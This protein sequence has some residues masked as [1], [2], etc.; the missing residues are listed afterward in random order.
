MLFLGLTLLGYISYRNLALELLPSVELPFLIIQVNSSREMDPDY[1]EK[2]AIIPLE[3]AIGTLEG[4]EK[5]ESYCGRRDGRII[6]YYIS[7]TNLKFAYLKMQ[8]KVDAVKPGLPDEFFV[9]VVKIDTELLTNMFMNLQ[10]RGGGGIDRVRNIFENQIRKELAAIDGIA[11]V[12]VFGGRE[13][14]VEIILNDETSA[15]YDIT[16][17]IVRS[18]IA[19]NTQRKMYV[20]QL[21]HQQNVIFIN[22]S[23][24]Y[25]DITDLENIVVKPEVPVLLKDVAKINFDV[26]EETSISRVNGKDAVT[27]QLIR[28][29]RINI[30]ALSHETRNVI[31]NINNNL[32]SQ[33]VEIFIQQDMA[34]YLEKNLDLIKNLALTGGILAI[35]ILWFFLRNLRLVAIIALALP[36]SILTAFNFF[37][38]FDITLN[39]L[40]LVGMALAV[41][42]LLDNSIVVLENIYRLIK[43]RRSAEYAVI[44]GTNEIW[45]SIFAATLTTII[46]FLPFIFAS[47]YMVRILGYQ[48]GVSI[49]ST[50]IVSLFVAL[51]L[52]P[53]AAHFLLEGRKNPEVKFTT[54]SLKNR[55]VQIY[56]VLLKSAMR[57]PLRTV[58][59]TLI[60]FFAS[61]LIAVAISLTGQREAETS[62]L[63]LYVTMPGGSTLENTDLAVTDLEE[64]LK[65]IAEVQDLVSQI[66]E[67]EAILTLNLK[68]DYQSIDGRDIGQIKELINGRIDEFS[69]AD[70][71]FDQPE[72]S[73]R[74]RGGG[75]NF[76][77]RFENMLGIGTQQEQ[78]VVKGRDFEVMRRVADDLVYHLEN[79]PAIARVRINV[80]DNR[81]EI[82]LLFDKDHMN[83]YGISLPAV[84][85]EL[86][87]FQR[88]FSS[89]ISYK[90]GSEDY[91]I[92]IRN[93]ELEDKT[94]EDLRVLPVPSQAGGSVSMQE[95]SRII[96][97]EGSSSINRVNQER[98]I[99]VTYMFMNEVQESTTF[100]EEAQAE[101]EQLI[102]SLEIPSGIAIEFGEDESDLSDFY[103]L[104]AV[105]FLLIYMIL[106]S[107]FESLLN[108][109]VIIFTIPLAAI[110]SL[111]A[112]IF[113]GNTILNANTLIGFL[114]LLGIVV[115]N[116]II[117]IDYT[118][119]LR[120][121]GNRR[122][123]AL[124]IAGKARLRPILITAI[125]T[126]VAMIP[127]AMGQVE[128]ITSIAAPFAI[129]VIGGLAL[130]TLFTLIFIPTVY[131]GLE[132]VLEW[133]KQLNWK[134]KAVQTVLLFGAILLIYYN[135]DNLIWQFANLCLALL[136]IPG[137]TYFIMNSLRRAKADVLISEKSIKIKVQNLYKIYD[138]PSR[139]IREWCKGKHSSNR[140]RYTSESVSWNEFYHSIWHL[141]LIGYLIYFVYI[142]LDHSLWLFI[143]VHPVY[144]YLIFITRRFQPMLA[145]LQTP[146]LVTQLIRNLEKIVLWI[147]PAI[148]LV[149]FY[150]KWDTIYVVLLIAAVW[151]F[152]LNVYSTSNRL[153]KNLVNVQRLK[154]R[155]S[156]LRRRY[157]GLIQSVPIIGKKTIPFQA[158]GGISLEI[159][160]G[161]F[162]LL[163]PNG[164]GKTTLM[165]VIC[166]VLDQ[167]YGSIRINNIDT[168]EKREELQGLIG[169]LPQ[170]FG[171]Y[172]NLTAYEFLS[173]Q[174]ILKNIYDR[175]ER[176]KR[177]VY[178]LGAVHMD[179]QRDEKIGSFSGGMKQRIGIA[180]TLLHLPRILVVDEP[181]AGLDP[182]ER[183]RFRN[184]LVELS[185]ERV[186]IFSTHIIEDIASSC[187]RV[188]VLNKG[189]IKYL[190]QPQNMAKLT[191]GFVWQC[192]LENRE[193]ESIRKKFTV[194]HHIKVKNK[195]RVRLLSK[196]KP[197]AAAENVQPTLEDSYLW[198]LES[199]NGENK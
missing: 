119:Q 58:V 11:N 6:V 23:A 128:Y 84:A 148:N 195:V 75:G 191:E 146:K 59:T 16:P 48:I 133:I 196:T 175:S 111:W 164:A 107:V 166:G 32:H 45:R 168:K 182:R 60:L 122:S 160:Q 98:Q 142:Y 47:N 13:K 89:G 24:E 152:A 72:A 5:I 139:F 129:T 125:T 124:M 114:I 140:S 2:E 29:A 70:V 33:D 88:E 106:A 55:I 35:L 99:E 131:S 188:A 145:T 1:M 53:M 104:A 78:L 199:Q 154:G 46:I 120:R 64:R 185:R 85:G 79:Q 69:A 159:S 173:Y 15:A 21:G 171:T 137:I 52:I 130:S 66:Y 176:E 87:T 4:I 190:G 93:E 184:L 179:Q 96:Y 115:N 51:F 138:Q 153:S 102:S 83:S 108:P 158:L 34:E 181:T 127:L 178:V 180:Q 105:A 132:G 82:H 9:T 10:V 74:F 77:N 183:I 177:I 192:L 14:T 91:D 42:M 134:L 165:R 150:L 76:S 136:V 17:S 63:N 118:R 56:M 20:G 112:I 174:A 3:G 44:E 71:S 197:L 109:V 141:P 157:Y 121:W 90:H 147:L 31:E 163:G 49:I 25:T 126:I 194:V 43:I 189:I 73:G 41:G 103:F 117:L 12:E 37:Y 50:L 94:M 27:V 86:A 28:D 95:I 19:Q 100:S 54:V 36:I 135:I 149:I 57:F 101:V 172:E 39:S 65:N 81:P 67:E 169:Y 167:S 143:L 161:M 7:D 68:E 151:Y 62:D 144:F 92:I 170:E 110:G 97:A 123:R 26:K 116:G 187:D 8:E 113:T 156:T 61:I 198:L 186:V 155:F 162:G 22:L 38:A 30:I 18:K 40:T 193:L 80:S